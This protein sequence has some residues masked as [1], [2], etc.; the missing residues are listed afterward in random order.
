MK[1]LGYNLKST[2]NNS[3]FT[4]ST[5]TNLGFSEQEIIDE[6]EKVVAKLND[7]EIESVKLLDL[8]SHDILLDKSKRSLAILEN[9]HLMGYEEFEEII[10]NIRTGINAG[11]IDLTNEKLIKLQ[12]IIFDKNEDFVSESE[13]KELALKVRNILKGE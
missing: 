1:K 5:G 11:L 6:F 12:R 3:V 13:L 7:L 2:K 9:A 10:H 8:N 4:L